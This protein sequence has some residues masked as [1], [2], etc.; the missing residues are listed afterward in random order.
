MCY[1][2]HVNHEGGGMYTLYS[3]Y[4]KNKLQAYHVRFLLFM[5]DRK[6]LVLYWLPRLWE[7]E[8]LLL[9]EGGRL[10][11]KG[12]SILIS[13]QFAKGKYFIKID[14]WILKA[15]GDECSLCIGLFFS[16]LM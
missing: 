4:F 9:F 13:W 15:F 10:S 2:L 8:E 11:K 5:A 16:I 7:D 3:S 1:I 12:I 14:L 6:I